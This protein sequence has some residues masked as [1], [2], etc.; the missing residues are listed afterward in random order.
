MEYFIETSQDREGNETFQ[1]SVS[2]AN[3]EI[4]FE[5]FYSKEDCLTWLEA[6]YPDAE[7]I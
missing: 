4:D 1:I 3:E 5:Q 7:E 6:N 2:V